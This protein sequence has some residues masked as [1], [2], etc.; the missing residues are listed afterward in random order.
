MTWGQQ[1]KL[2]HIDRMDNSRLSESGYVLYKWQI[3]QLGNSPPCDEQRFHVIVDDR[4]ELS[5]SRY[6][7][8]DLLSL[9]YNS[10]LVDDDIVSIDTEYHHFFFQKSTKFSSFLPVKIRATRHGQKGLADYQ[11]L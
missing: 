10:F 11:K 2:D 7:F 1:Q 9:I 5:S 6:S 3:S 4:Q 8:T